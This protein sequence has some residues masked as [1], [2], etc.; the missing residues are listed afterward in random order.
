MSGVVLGSIY[1]AWRRSLFMKVEVVKYEEKHPQRPTCFLLRHRCSIVTFIGCSPQFWGQNGHRSIVKAVTHFPLLCRKYSGT[2][3]VFLFWVSVVLK[4]IG[5]QRL[6]PEQECVCGLTSVCV[7]LGC[8]CQQWCDVWLTATLTEHEKE[9]LT[10][11]D[12]HRKCRHPQKCY[13]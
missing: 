1:L 4:S 10:E 13:E 3:R 12:Q 11:R 2:F 6:L 9:N 5:L 7:F 8:S